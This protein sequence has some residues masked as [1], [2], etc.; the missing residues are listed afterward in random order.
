MTLFISYTYKLRLCLYRCQLLE[1]LC[2]A[3]AINITYRCPFGAV[4]TYLVVSARASQGWKC[5]F[6][7]GKAWDENETAWSYIG[8]P[9]FCRVTTREDR[10]LPHFV[11]DNS[12]WALTS[13]NA[14]LIY[15]Q[16]LKNY[17]LRV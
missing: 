10:L 3:I 15:F 4:V 17:P 7:G 8:P 9:P 5:I 13:S 11:Y 2:R 1:R 16:S 12:I 6:A 14:L